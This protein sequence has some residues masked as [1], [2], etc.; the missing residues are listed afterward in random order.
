MGSTLL[1]IVM[2][3]YFGTLRRDVPVVREASR[4][5]YELWPASGSSADAT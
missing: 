5:A 4:E 3:A 1:E 2:D